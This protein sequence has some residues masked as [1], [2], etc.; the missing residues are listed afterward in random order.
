MK[1]A[2][3]AL[4]IAT[5]M[6]MAGCTGTKAQTTATDA[7]GKELPKVYFIKEITP[8]NIVKIYN[9]LG[10]KAQG[11]NVAVKLSTGE[12]GN[13]NHLSPALIKD[14]VQSV[15]GTII[16]GNTAYAGRRNT[17][18]DH[19]KT[20]EEHGFT[21][22]ADVDILDA[23]G[24]VSLPIEGGRHLKEDIVGKNF[25]NY[26]FLMVLSHFKGHPMGGFGGALKA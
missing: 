3:M 10:R 11:K 15:N 19:L 26:D 16:E 23:D 24:Q 17:T 13:P 2:V 6:S 1:K 18:A 9:A 20:A 7:Q 5:G 4:A 25:L 12:A 8:E 14:L 22:I 21:A